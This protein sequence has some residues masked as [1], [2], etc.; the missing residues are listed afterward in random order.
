MMARIGSRK[1]W[2]R[3]SEIL[4]E[5]PVTSTARMMKPYWLHVDRWTSRPFYVTIRAVLVAW[6]GTS[7]P[8]PDD[9]WGEMSHALEEDKEIRVWEGS[10]CHLGRES[11]DTMYGGIRRK[12]AVAAPGGKSAG[13][14]GVEGMT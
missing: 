14:N 1:R 13:R 3:Y 11:G 6:E 8:S 10:G 7:V 4:T 9:T 12:A 2:I 5:V